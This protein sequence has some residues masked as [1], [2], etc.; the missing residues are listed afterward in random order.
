MRQLVELER[1][2][3]MLEQQIS[4]MLRPGVVVSTDPARGTVR[5]QLGDADGLVSHDLPV[6]QR[7]TLKDKDYQMPDV[8][9]HM[10]ACFLPYGQEQGFALG[11]LFSQADGVPEAAG[12]DVFAKQF[13]DGT[14]IT[15]DRAAHKLVAN[16]KGDAEVT[17]EKSLTAT[18]QEGATVHSKKLLTLMGKEGVQV[19]TA[20]FTIGPYPG[21]ETCLTD[22]QGDMAL[23]GSLRHQGDYEQQ[24]NHRLSGDVEAAGKVTDTGGNTNHHEH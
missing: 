11:S 16:V 7:K 23:T 18:A 19:L 21:G 5:L 9:E 10:L 13:A 8:G 15:Y 20:S 24:G 4:G 12:Q 1:R 6:L 17:T 3:R 22:W 14:S 2:V